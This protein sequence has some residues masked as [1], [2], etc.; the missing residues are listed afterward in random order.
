MP[1]KIT[2]TFTEKDLLKKASPNSIFYIIQITW[3]R[4]IF[5]SIKH[6]NFESVNR[7]LI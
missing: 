2:L 5:R 6:F 4:G 3:K 1:L 7:V